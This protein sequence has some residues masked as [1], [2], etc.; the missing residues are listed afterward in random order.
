M[1]RIPYKQEALSNLEC[2]ACGLDTVNKT[3]KDIE[4]FQ[5]YTIESEHLVLDKES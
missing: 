4:W 1:V 5:M 3:D 2:P